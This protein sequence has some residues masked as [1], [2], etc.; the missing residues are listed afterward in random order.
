MQARK[1]GNKV[2]SAAL[3]GELRQQQE[4]KQP[5]SKSKKNVVLSTSDT[6]PEDHQTNTNEAC[7]SE[8]P[9]KQQGVL[10]VS[11][12]NSSPPPSR[13]QSELLSEAGN[14]MCDD[15]LNALYEQMDTLDAS[16]SQKN[17]HQQQDG[18]PVSQSRSE[19]LATLNSRSQSETLDVGTS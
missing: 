9:T 18:Q 13:S 16:A 2:S 10:S 17:Q 7:D 12:S 11:R 1:A 8:H 15:A 19:N 6:K 5:T 14:I 3:F 4:S